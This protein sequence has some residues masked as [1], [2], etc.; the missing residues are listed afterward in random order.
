MRLLLF[1]QFQ[2]TRCRGLV[3]YRS[4][5]TLLDKAFSHVAHGIFVDI[6]Q[7]A[8]QTVTFAFIAFQQDVR[9][10]DNCRFVLPFIDHCQQFSSFF[11]G[12]FDHIF[13][14]HPLSLPYPEFSASRGTRSGAGRGSLLPRR[15]ANPDQHLY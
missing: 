5:Q 10:A 9:P 3:F 1:I 2:F 11:G 8:D 12:E 15:D 4:L 7:F 6:Q 13:L 14:I